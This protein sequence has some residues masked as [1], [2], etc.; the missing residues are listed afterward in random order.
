MLGSAEAIRKY[1]GTEKPVTFA[2]L[3]ELL[4]SDKAGYYWM[5]N[6]CAKAL[7]EELRPS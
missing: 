4:K 6:E 7:G 5:A 1:M 3:K 2:E